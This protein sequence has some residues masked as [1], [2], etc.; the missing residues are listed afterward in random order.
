MQ[1]APNLTT[2]QKVFWQAIPKDGKPE[3]NTVP[4]TGTATVTSN[5]PSIA[6]PINTQPGGLSGE[7]Q[8]HAEGACI[9]TVTGSN[10][11][12]APYSSSFSVAVTAVP[13][14]PGEPTHFVFTFGTPA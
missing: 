7:A 9:F 11:L 3:E 12:G 6:S 5:D 14:A 4:N 13:G 2:I 10:S 8:A 1:A